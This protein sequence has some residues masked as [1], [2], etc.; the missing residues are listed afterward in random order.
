MISV[1]S[2]HIEILSRGTLAPSQTME[3]FF[4]GESVPVKE[5]LSE[6]FL[7]LHIS[8]KS[9]RG[10]TKIVETY[11]QQAISFNENSIVVT[12]PFNRINAV[13]SRYLMKGCCDKPRRLSVPIV[14][15]VDVGGSQN[16]HHKLQTD[17]NFTI[18]IVPLR[19]TAIRAIL[20]VCSTLEWPP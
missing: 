16:Q 9:G 10:V 19:W 20:I 1:F 8:E 11:G 6:I 5:R 14:E 3:G 15:R 13:L 7:Q 12:I 4:S 2:N 17:V 18:K